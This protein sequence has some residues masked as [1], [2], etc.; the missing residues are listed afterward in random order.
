MK[1][2]KILV[3]IVILISLIILFFIGLFRQNSNADIKK[4]KIS[5]YIKSNTI[6]T[7]SAVIQKE[8][9][10]EQQN[11][12]EQID[13]Q[14][15]ENI[16]VK[17]ENGISKTNVENN[18]KTI[19]TSKSNQVTQSV[20]SATET[21]QKTQ[22]TNSVKTETQ[23]VITKQESTNTSKN[24]VESFKVNN[25]I[26]AQMKNIINSNPST[27]MKQFGYNI[28]VDSSIV[29]QTTGFTYTETRVKNSIT[30]NFGTI[31]IYARDYFVG[32]EL[33]WTEGFIL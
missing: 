21:N 28:I 32:N 13:E 17:I 31:R 11:N 1:M 14:Q 29:N 2:K 27:Y 7:A 23:T 19:N 9:I 8:V 15:E 20:Q 30:N 16:D 10:D 33:R 24:N 25:S 26:I 4:I 3:F 6:K 18:K 12:Q 5:D 22:E